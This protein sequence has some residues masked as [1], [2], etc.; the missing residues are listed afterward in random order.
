MRGGGEQLT[1][2]MIA[3]TVDRHPVGIFEIIGCRRTMEDSVIANK[4]FMGATEQLYGGTANFVCLRVSVGWLVGTVGT[5]GVAI[6]TAI[7][8]RTLLSPPPPHFPS[9]VTPTPARFLLL[10]PCSV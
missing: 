2:P 9:T 10:I 1:D 6:C 7:C 4:I 5:V 3:G 8:A